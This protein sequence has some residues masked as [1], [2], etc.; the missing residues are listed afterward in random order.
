I[1]TL[2]NTSEDELLRLAAAVETRSGHTL[3]QAVVQK[4]AERKLNLP[5]AGE[6]QSVTG[7][8]VMA[9][10]EG[11]A[12]KIGNLKFFEKN[13]IDGFNEIVSKVEAL[14][15]EGK[16]TMLVSA[17]DKFL[18]ILALADQP[19]DMAKATLAKLKQLGIQKTIMITGDNDRVAAAIA[20]AMGITEY[21]A[22]LMPDDKVTAIKE[23]L[24]KYGE[25]A[26]VGDGVNDAP[27]MATSTVGIAMGTAGSDVALETADVAL[28]ADDLSKLPFAVALSRQ[29]RRII[30]QNLIISLGV[31]AMLIP[32]AL[33]GIAGIGIAI[34]FH[35]GSTLLVVANALRLLRFK[36]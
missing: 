5:P 33:F 34:V 19:R 11:R 7:K 2:N 6:L 8:G 12:I 14:Q 21:R 32:S 23:L 27:A 25:V 17:D 22:E 26:M 35:E 1:V 29:A 18:G 3:A 9:Q 31:I 24:A 10:V 20:K 36:S 30:L 4:A 13:E 16:T 15:A 28:M